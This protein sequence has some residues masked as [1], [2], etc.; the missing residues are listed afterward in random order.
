MLRLSKA[1]PEEFSR[2]QAAKPRNNIPSAVLW[3]SEAGGGGGG[4]TT[5]GHSAFDLVHGE[6]GKLPQSQAVARWKPVF[7]TVPHGDKPE[8]GAVSP[9]AVTRP[10]STVSLIRGRRQNVSGTQK[11]Q[12]KKHDW[13]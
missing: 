8:P 4:G 13:F 9:S 5:E 1:D 6:E 12:H 7:A 11:N 3:L 10:S 2:E